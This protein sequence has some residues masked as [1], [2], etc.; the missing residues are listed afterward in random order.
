MTY[1]PFK[2]NYLHELK[3]FKMSYWDHREILLQEIQTGNLFYVDTL[4]TVII[5]AI[6]INGFVQVADY[7]SNEVSEKPYS[8]K[9]L[10]PIDLPGGAN[11]SLLKAYLKHTKFKADGYER[12]V[13]DFEDY[14]IILERGLSS[15]PNFG[16]YKREKKKNK[17]EKTIEF[18]HELQNHYTLL[19]EQRLVINSGNLIEN[20]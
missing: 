9:K 16:M 14:K 4:R 5:T 18:M 13:A 19:S 1:L 15:W 11:I 6:H 3:K 20:I 17:K 10:S 2:L 7:L 12:F 8:I